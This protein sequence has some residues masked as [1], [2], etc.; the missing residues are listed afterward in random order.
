VGS[1]E[2]QRFDDLAHLAADC[3]GGLNGGAGG[4]WQL[5]HL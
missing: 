1:A 4:R 3:L 5:Y 2:N